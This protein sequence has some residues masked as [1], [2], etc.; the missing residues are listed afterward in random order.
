MASS[1]SS[2]LNE[3]WALKDKE[4]WANPEEKGEN[5]AD[6][7]W[8]VSDDV[9]LGAALEAEERRLERV[10]LTS[11]LPVSKG[12]FD[13]AIMSLARLVGGRAFRTFPPDGESRLL[14]V[15]GKAPMSMLMLEMARQST[16]T[17]VQVESIALALGMWLD[18]EGKWFFEPDNPR[19]EEDVED[20][21]ESEEE[22]EDDEDEESEES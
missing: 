11:L 2:L 4:I 17:V 9:D 5:D 22:E 16:A 3:E 1:I 21:E 20:V 7:V 15:P 8:N 10:R 18:E 19:T 14:I 13:A 6:P 12:E